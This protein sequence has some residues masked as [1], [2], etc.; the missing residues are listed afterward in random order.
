MFGPGVWSSQET[1]RPTTSDS[2][3]QARTT[4]TSTLGQDEETKRFESLSKITQQHAQEILG[5]QGRTTN[6]I[7]CILSTNSASHANGYVQISLDKAVSR[8]P[9][10]GHIGTNPFIHQLTFIAAGDLQLL[11]PTK[12]HGTHQVSHLCYNGKCFNRR[13][14]VR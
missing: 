2:T 7:G 1:A 9:G 8:I 6:N 13:H 4:Y 14:L 3:T 5:R 12:Q 11:L 10:K